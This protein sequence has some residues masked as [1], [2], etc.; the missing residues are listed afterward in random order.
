MNRKTL[1]KAGVSPE[2]QKRSD[3]MKSEGPNASLT[4]LPV[5]VGGTPFDRVTEAVGWLLEQKG[6]KNVELGKTAFDPGNQ[7]DMAQMTGSL[8]E[9]VKFSNVHGFRSVSEAF[10]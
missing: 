10:R 3:L 8:G 2:Q 1:A 5:R 4:I 9:F 6:L 7:T